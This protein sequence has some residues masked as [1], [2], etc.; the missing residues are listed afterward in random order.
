MKIGGDV[1]TLE[2]PFAEVAMRDLKVGDQVRISGLVFTGRDRFHSYLHKG[3][4]TPVNLRDGA[5][6]HC[7]PVVV[8]QGGAWV[9]K[10]AGP[11][12]SIR[13]EPY[14]D[15]IIQ[16]HGVRMIIGKGG[17]GRKTRKACSECGC[18]YVQTVG[19]AAGILAKRINRVRGVHFLQEFGGAEAVWEL[20]VCNLPGVV[21]MDTHGDSLHDTVRRS[22]GRALG[23]LMESRWCV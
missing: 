10:A 5:I 18:V 8:Q 9:V 17:M 16:K 20:V 14:M 12:T 23:R 19:G 13:D 6:Y 2:Y 15:S 22:S 11:T 21:T 7:G 4:R 1:K 3:G